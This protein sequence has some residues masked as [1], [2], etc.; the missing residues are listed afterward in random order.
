[1]FLNVR[2]QQ[3]A[4]ADAEC[5]FR[6]RRQQVHDA[7]LWLKEHNRYYGDISVS[8]KN[9]QQLPDDDP[10]QLWLDQYMTGT[11]RAHW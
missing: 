2:S 3:S 9:L 1:M 4:N 7:F 10:L 8:V 11:R 6:A 5:E